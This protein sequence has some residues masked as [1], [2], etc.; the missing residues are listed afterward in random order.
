LKAF[1]RGVFDLRYIRDAGT[2]SK[3]NLRAIDFFSGQVKCSEC[4]RSKLNSESL[5]I[6]IQG[7]SIAE[8]SKLPISELLL[9]I[10][11]LPT[12]LD[13]HELKISNQGID[14]IE[15]RL[16]YLNNIGLKALSTNR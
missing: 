1:Y 4:N 3:G 13:E 16:I 11:N 8:V 10:Q 5:A 7:Q 2:N 6:T 14:E 12:S 15:L 9:V